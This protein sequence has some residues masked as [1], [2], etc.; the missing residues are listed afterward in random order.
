MTGSIVNFAL[1]FITCLVFWG[2]A[3]RV[4]VTITPYEEFTMVAQG[5][6]AA[7]YSLAGTALGLAAPLASLAMHAGSLADLAAWALLGL[8]TQLAFWWALAR[9]VF[10]DLTAAMQAD[11]QSVGIVLGAFSATVGML[12]A[13]CLSY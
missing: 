9:F 12:N 4:Y 8:V 11:R 5:N 7:A 10:R 1:Y 13:A 6:K 2:A 3:M